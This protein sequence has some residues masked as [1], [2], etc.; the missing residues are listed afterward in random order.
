MCCI[1]R[2]SKAD[3]SDLIQTAINNAGFDAA[4]NAS[5]NV[6]IAKG[7]RG[8]AVSWTFT[9]TT[10]ELNQGGFIGVFRHRSVQSCC[11]ARGRAHSGLIGAVHS[12]TTSTWLASSLPS[13]AG[14]G[15]RFPSP[16]CRGA[17]RRIPD[18]EF[19]IALLARLG[20]TFPMLAKVCSAAVNGIDAYPAEVEVNSRFGDTIIVMPSCFLPARVRRKT[21]VV[22]IV[23]TDPFSS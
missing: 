7:G 2:V 14:A 8:N 5:G 20:H 12:G 6:N 9:S 10:G 16:G 13:K 15:R 19:L 21:G 23:L 17:S 22:S 11:C 3:K 1:V 4:V 18:A